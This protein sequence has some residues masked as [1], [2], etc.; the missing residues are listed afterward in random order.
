M[1]MEDSAPRSL[2]CLRCEEPLTFAGT[3]YFHEGSRA[4]D[5]IG[6]KN[7]QALDA[8]LLAEWDCASCG[9]AVPANFE[10]C[11]NCSAPRP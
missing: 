7:H 6:F 2:A 11:W 4:W 9:E 1:N 5:I 10:V 3:K 8:D